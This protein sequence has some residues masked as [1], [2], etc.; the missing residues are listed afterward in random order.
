VGVALAQYLLFRSFVLRELAWT[1]PL[2][3]DQL[4]YL[5]QAYGLFDAMRS[6]RGARELLSMLAGHRAQIAA[7]GVMLPTQASLLFFLRGAS[8]LTALTLNLAY[9][10]LWQVVTLLCVRSISG[11]I[12]LAAV[13]WGLVLA[14]HSPFLPI[15]GLTD[16]RGDSIA[17]SLFGAFVAIVLA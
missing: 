16:F 17:L 3:D 12:Y 5:T 15:G 4:L 9:Y 2:N 10:V 7:N 11:S 8:R 14:V 6:P 1:Y 13:A